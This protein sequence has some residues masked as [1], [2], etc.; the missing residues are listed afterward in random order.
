MS[1]VGYPPGRVT[2][3]NNLHFISGP[4]SQIL[5]Y[6]QD[7]V[8]SSL[9]FQILINC[10]MRSCHTAS[11]QRPSNMVFLITRSR[12]RW[13][14]AESLSFSYDDKN[15]ETRSQYLLHLQRI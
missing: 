9:L 7:P 10:D 5:T 2:P 1:G 12:G 14:F 8:I 4:V 11:P 13:D 15:N 3:N 6:A